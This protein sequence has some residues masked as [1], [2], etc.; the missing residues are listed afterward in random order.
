MQEMGQIIKYLAVQVR[1][2]GVQ[3]ELGKEVTPELIDE[4]KPDVVIA[5][6]GAAPLVPESIPGID[7]G[8]VVTAWDVLGGHGAAT[9]RKVVIVGGGLTGCETADFLA[10][11]NDNLLAAPTEVTLLEMREEIAMDSMA[12]PRHLLLDRLREKR[13]QVLCRAEVKEILDDGV[14]FVRDGKEEALH[15][16]EYVILAMG[17]RPADEL[18]TK[19]QDKVSEVYL[20]GD[21]K[22]PRRV[23][24]ATTEAADIGRRI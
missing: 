1:K 4:L 24:D 7:K 6:T 2:A 11:T 15:G 13:V 23:L 16:A 17:V 22:Q 14:V 12:E 8:T 10:L 19:I 9:A 21:A 3:V 5:A 20:I 18:M